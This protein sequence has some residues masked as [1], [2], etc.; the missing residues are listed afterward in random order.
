MNLVMRP[1]L[2]WWIATTALWL[3]VPAT[4][5]A[6]DALVVFTADSEGQARPC[7]SCP[8]GEVGG[9]A[10]RQT[11]LSALRQGKRP[12]F[13]V[14]AGNALYGDD[15]ENDADRV[16][17]A[18]HGRLGYDVLNVSYR[19]FRHGYQQTLEFLK[20]APFAAISANLVDGEDGTLLFPPFHVQQVG[21]SRMGVIGVTE[22]PP[23]LDSLPHLREQLRDVSIRPPLEALETHLPALE[24]SADL[25][26]LLY[27]GSPRGLEE[28]AARFGDRLAWIGAGGFPGPRLPGSLAGK[29]AVVPPRGV[30][31]ATVSGLGAELTIA[32]LA[33]DAGVPPDPEVTAYLHDVVATT[34]TAPGEAVR[35]AQWSGENRALRLD[36]LAVT[37]LEAEGHLALETRWENRMPLDLIVEL[38]YGESGSVADLRRQAFLVVDDRVVLRLVPDAEELPGHL[39]SEFS[40]EFGETREGRLVFPLRA[41]RPQSRLELVFHTQTFA[42]LRIPLGDPT[43][44]EAATE[45]KH[46]LGRNDV[47][48]LGVYRFEKKTRIGEDEAPA[49]ATFVVCDVRGRSLIEK[50][51]D[52]LALDETA[53]RQARAALPLVFEYREAPA[54]LQLLVDGEEAYTR[55]QLQSTLE[56]EPPFLPS[57]LAGGEAVFLIPADARSLELVACF[58]TMRLTTGRDLGTPTTLRFPLEGEAPSPSSDAAVR[59]DEDPLPF[60]V[61]GSR[62]L[63]RL[64][65]YR[66][67]DGKELFI[68]SCAVQNRGVEGGLYEATGRLR[69][70]GAD[71][72]TLALAVTDRIGLPLDEPLW[73]PPGERRSFHAVFEVPRDSETAEFSYRGV[74][75]AA[76]FTLGPAG[77]TSAA[78]PV[79][80]AQQPVDE[81]VPTAARTEM[82]SR[83]PRG[84]A[85]VGLTAQQV[86]DAIDRGR[87]FLWRTVREESKGDL[88]D[89]PAKRDHTIA[90][91]ALV[92]CGAHREYPE[93]DKALRR[94]FGEML[95]PRSA[96]PQARWVSGRTYETAVYAMAID[97]Y[98]D[99]TFFP[100]LER[101][102]QTLV[103]G[104]APGGT[105]T[106]GLPR[107]EQAASTTEEEGMPLFTVLEPTAVG[108]EITRTTEWRDF[109][110]DNSVGQFAILGLRAAHRRG[111]RASQKTWSAARESYRSRQ[112]KDGGWSYREGGRSYGSMTCAGV[113]S[114]LLTRWAMGEESPA[115]SAGIE[116]GLAWLATNFSAVRNPNSSRHKFYYLYSIERVGRLFD[117]DF[118]GEHEW[119]PLGARSL[120]DWQQDDGRWEERR[121][122]IVPTS[123][124]LLFLTRATETLTP[125]TP[126]GPG[127]LRTSLKTAAAPRYY[128]IFDASGSMLARM[129]ERRK[130]DIAREALLDLIKE[131]PDEARVA[132]RVYGH[133][134]RAIED[135]AA[136]DTELIVR[137]QRLGPRQ[138]QL[139]VDTIQALR[140]RG[141]TPLGL[142]LRDSVNDLRRLTSRAQTSV[143]LLSDGGDDTRSGIDPMESAEAMGKLRDIRL[144][145]VGF[146]VD[147]PN[148]ARQLRD[149]AT[150]SG[151]SHLDPANEEALR[152]SLRGAFGQVDDAFTVENADGEVVGEGRLGDTLELPPGPYRL[153]AA[154]F[155]ARQVSGFRIRPEGTTAVVCNAQRAPAV[156]AQ[157]APA[158]PRKR[159]NFCTGCGTKLA[160]KWNFCT[161]CGQRI[162]P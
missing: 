47:V 141:L 137:M 125:D 22:P 7:S 89:F 42:P 161:N 85:G 44:P 68:L 120:V 2:H 158:T 119:Y 129:G 133:R 112:G 34:T 18:L 60:E 142:S 138:R 139:L 27:Y 150:A 38:E 66:A 82:S 63:T 45:P 155:G 8:A 49:G 106:Y 122:T 32:P 78:E 117:T 132:L 96:A 62:R 9:F 53:P 20:D 152:Q 3:A 156:E 15:V 121:E 12:V 51:T 76:R 75:R 26:V 103:D 4:V 88:S 30:E 162:T 36:V 147:S 21:T 37:R 11:I 35:A 5:S 13:V 160:A 159:P 19:D 25:V 134:K 105:W 55:L 102:T 86:N 149:I 77:Q 83:E 109:N 1:Q 43:Q 97:A 92:H 17:V 24:D 39:P 23:Y 98:G 115:E 136:E 157:A 31:L 143:V 74:S 144:T 69:L 111:F 70:A 110:G 57:P 131:L 126:T 123:F 67:S 10:R 145:V 128:V 127:L 99:P 73:L 146:A 154:P 94:W 114:L 80:S 108:A 33:V 135:G 116:R 48:E 56:A 148:G 87:D 40:L 104:Q 90:A 71:G 130:F 29:V 61:I 107:P 65:E 93:L 64:G 16:L 118:L 14:D 6:S 124:A 58:P 84:L 28:I 113:C 153:V 81:A 140:P 79:V 151:G 50:E 100:V 54:L 52:A 46:G 41:C 59:V 95:N 72:E 101:L 91:L